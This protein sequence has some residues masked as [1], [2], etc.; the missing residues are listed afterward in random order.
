[1]SLSINGGEPSTIVAE[2][3][4]ARADVDLKPGA[5]NLL[6]VA[7]GCAAA[8]SIDLHGIPYHLDGTFTDISVLAGASRSFTDPATGVC[9]MPEQPYRPGSWGYVGGEPYT[10]KT[11]LAAFRP[12]T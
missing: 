11:G 7:G 9:W 5:N 2:G 1:M 12:P 10:L 4:V 6:A 8:I 3:G